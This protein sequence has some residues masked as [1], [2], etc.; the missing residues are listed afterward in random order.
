MASRLT[1]LTVGNGSTDNGSIGVK[2]S[3][4]RDD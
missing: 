4:R 2:R 1:S 3:A